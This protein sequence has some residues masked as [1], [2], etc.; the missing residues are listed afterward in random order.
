LR[1]RVGRGGACD[2]PEPLE[3][4]LLLTWR[5]RG[6]RRDREAHLD[7]RV[8]RV[9]VLPTRSTGTGGAPLELVEPDHAGPV[10]PH[11]TTVRDRLT[12]VARA[13]VGHGGLGY[14]P[15]TFGLG[16]VP[17][18]SEHM[19]SAAVSTRLRT[20][21]GAAAVALLS[22]TTVLVAAAPSASAASNPKAGGS[23][24]Y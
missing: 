4:A 6:R 16:D 19:S 15:V 23:V 18:G 10:H 3:Q 14:R 1:P 12:R 2:R 11:D 5:E 7:A 8:R 22:A 9:G 17:G 24:T 21:L 20:R 13:V